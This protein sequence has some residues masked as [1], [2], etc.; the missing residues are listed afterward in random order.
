MQ[1]LAES[2]DLAEE[3]LASMTAMTQVCLE[4]RRDDNALAYAHQA[5]KLGEERDPE[6]YVPVLRSLLARAYASSDPEAGILLADQAAAELHDI[7]VP[8]RTQVQMALATAYLT[9]GKKE[10][11]RSMA[12]TVLQTAGSRGF[13]LLSLEARALLASLGTEGE[14]ATHRAVGQELARDFTTG[15]SPEMARSFARRPFL[16]WLDDP[17]QD[18]PPAPKAI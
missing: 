3:V 18:A 2:I 14:A 12:R 1:A 11:A 10:Q 5:L 15:L 13:R 17:V 9:L 6:R 16:K 7:P 8:R 4:T